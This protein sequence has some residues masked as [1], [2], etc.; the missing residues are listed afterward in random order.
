MS[1]CLLSV[2]GSAAG[3]LQVLPSPSP[4][5]SS[6]SS[7]AISTLP[8][9]QFECSS[10][11]WSNDLADSVDR[12]LGV[13]QSLSQSES[14]SW[15]SSPSPIMPRLRFKFIN[16]Q[17]ISLWLLLV[18]WTDHVQTINRCRC[19]SWSFAACE[20]FCQ[21]ISLSLLSLSLSLSL[22]CL[23]HFLIFQFFFCLLFVSVRFGSVSFVFSAFLSTAQLI[24]KRFRLALIA[25]AFVFTVDP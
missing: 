6:S 12:R 4:S 2:W 25:F 11:D 19:R 20:S 14:Q 17:I 18:L 5:P 3:T 8:V 9:C 1:S 22:P 16:S 21:F 15:S 7:L 10:I 13:P 24:K 23:S